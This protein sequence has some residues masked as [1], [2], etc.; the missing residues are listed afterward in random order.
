M[1]IIVN[2][3]ERISVEKTPGEDS[4]HIEIP[5]GRDRIHHVYV[6]DQSTVEISVDCDGIRVVV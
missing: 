5:Q 2:E 4:I 6:H 1:I 3:D